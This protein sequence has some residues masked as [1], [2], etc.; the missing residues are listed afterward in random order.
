M[1][2][3]ENFQHSNVGGNFDDFERLDNY[4]IHEQAKSDDSETS[5][6]PLD[7]DVRHFGQSNVTGLHS[8]DRPLVTPG[9]DPS[10]TMSFTPHHQQPPPIAICPISTPETVEIHL[11]PDPEEN[12]AAEPFISIT[13]ASSVTTTSTPASGANTV[14]GGFQE[15]DEEE[16]EDDREEADQYAGDVVV[17][18]NRYADLDQF[19]HGDEFLP[20]LGPRPSAPEPE[21]SLLDSYN[22]IA[23]GQH[24]PVVEEIPEV[25]PDLVNLEMSTSDRDTFQD[26][27]EGVAFDLK[28]IDRNLKED[29]KQNKYQEEVEEEEKKDDDFGVLEKVERAVESTLVETLNFDK[30]ESKVSFVSE[31]AP[32][33]DD[34][35]DK[36]EFREK[37]QTPDKDTTKQV[38]NVEGIDFSG[39][40]MEEVQ[41]EETQ[42]TCTCSPCK[43]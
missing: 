23:P 15:E 6:S 33:T 12:R 9:T 40:K 34:V 8:T 3:F 35:S 38:S 14:R 30:I 16:E 24:H 20:Q 28:D 31:T 2:D 29:L 43:F 4:P 11:T 22:D 36:E 26:K 27:G 25:R 41:P 10:H 42:N 17:E 1:S 13:S 19:G 18:K 7:D 5:G 21:P 39:S 37:R 32:K